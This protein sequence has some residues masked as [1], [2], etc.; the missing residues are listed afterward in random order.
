MRRTPR[1]ERTGGR[2]LFMSTMPRPTQLDDRP[3]APWN[4]T[5][6]ARAGGPRLSPTTST[7]STTSAPAPAVQPRASGDAGAEPVLPPG[8]V[9]IVWALGDT[10]AADVVARLSK[11]DARLSAALRASE[12][13][14]AARV[15]VRRDDRSFEASLE[16]EFGD[17][18]SGPERVLLASGPGATVRT[19]QPAPG[20]RLIH[21]DV[22]GVLRLTLLEDRTADSP[23]APSRADAK[24]E[25]LLATTPLLGERLQVAGGAADAPVLTLATS[26]PTH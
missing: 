24:F 14:H 25:L 26:R 5:G 21:A 23:G 12:K 10:A 11:S 15:C 17:R 2:E 3:G 8:G 20:L 4:A 18:T 19:S 7:A 1:I 22:P 9:C 16:L 6:L 13:L